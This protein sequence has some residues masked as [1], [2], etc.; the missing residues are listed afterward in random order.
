MA[1]TSSVFIPVLS[2]IP[3]YLRQNGNKAPENANNGIFQDAFGINSHIY[4][5]YNQN[6]VE[7]DAFHSMMVHRPSTHGGMWTD[8]IP[9]QWIVDKCLPKRAPSDEFT[10][11]DMGASS[12]NV[13]EAFRQRLPI[14]KVRLILQDLP[15][16]IQGKHHST[17]MCQAGTH[18]PGDVEK[19]DHDFFTPQPV[20]AAN[21][22]IL[23][24]ALHN[25]PDK[26]ASKILQHIQAAMN[27][28]STLLIYDTLF[29]DRL[30]DASYYD[31]VSDMIMMAILASLER[32]ESQFRDLLHSVGLVLVNV[33]RSPV[34]GDKQ[35]I[36]EIALKN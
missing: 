22:Y 32:T 11:V 21:I 34:A 23:A 35:A 12:S 17:S 25:W 1:E 27:E 19:M 9:E 10:V 15:N 3:V 29:S 26:E 8:Y 28:H 4:D 2:R 24:R 16:V 14:Q 7:H 36:L 5:W 20:R 31:A 6:P 30:E 18:A 13:L 33:W